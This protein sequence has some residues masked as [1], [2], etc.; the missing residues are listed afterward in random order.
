MADVE[1]TLRIREENLAAITVP[2]ADLMLYR[3]TD[4]YL[5]EVEP[6]VYRLGVEQGVA[7]SPLS[8]E[9]VMKEAGEWGEVE[10][11][12]FGDR[13]GPAPVTLQPIVD[14]R[15]EVC[16]DRLTFPELAEASGKCED[17][18]HEEQCAELEERRR[19]ES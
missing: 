13:E 1:I 4:P 16:G 18:I 6:G 14:E 2:A 10:E 15:C 17:C 5:V 9:D 7:P 3:G 12:F 8:P 11:A 19:A